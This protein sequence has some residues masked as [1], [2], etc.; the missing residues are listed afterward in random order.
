MVVVAAVLVMAPGSAN[1]EF[2]LIF[3]DPATNGIDYRIAD[4]DPLDL[5]DEVGTIS[6]AIDD[7]KLT[8]VATAAS[9]PDKGSPSNPELVLSINFLRYANGSLEIKG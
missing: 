6:V 4:G 7:G 5:L 9:K 8:A 1:A 2:T 3:D